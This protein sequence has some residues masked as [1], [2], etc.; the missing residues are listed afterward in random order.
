M[1]ETTNANLEKAFLIKILNE[2][3]QFYKVKPHFFANDQIRLI[4]EVVR[5]NYIT[6]T[7]KIVPSFKQIWLM[8]SLVDTTNI[9]SKE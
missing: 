3:D 5:E 9:V 8:V 7:N 1:I 4:Y 2:P 6:S